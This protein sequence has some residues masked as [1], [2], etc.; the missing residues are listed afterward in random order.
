MAWLV[1]A[2]LLAL[3]T[4]GRRTAYLALI[5]FAI[6]IVARVVLAGSHF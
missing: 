3:R 1:Y 2:G 4:T 6:V 5:G